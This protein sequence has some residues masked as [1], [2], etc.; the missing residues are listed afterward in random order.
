MQWEPINLHIH[1]L[2][3]PFM[4]IC[5]DQVE[6]YQYLRFFP[7]GLQTSNCVTLY[8]CLSDG[9]VKCI[10]KVGKGFDKYGNVQTGYRHL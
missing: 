6:Y 3:T 10:I 4:C 2:W 1:I 9:L 5:V 8:V 7:I